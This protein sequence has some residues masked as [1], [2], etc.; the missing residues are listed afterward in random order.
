MTE[1]FVRS[2]HSMTQS[3]TLEKI[4][5]VIAPTKKAAP[6]GESLASTTSIFFTKGPLSPNLGVC[7]S[8]RMDI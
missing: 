3:Q 4:S 2:V 1:D 5:A 6:A 7:S 8:L